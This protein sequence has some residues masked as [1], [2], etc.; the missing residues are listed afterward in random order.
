MAVPDTDTIDKLQDKYAA[1]IIASGH[2][3]PAILAK[4]ELM[5]KLQAK[6][7]RNQKRNPKSEP[8]R[9]GAQIRLRSTT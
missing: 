1:A 4:L 8:P 2:L 9:D 7:A 6:A 3:P 5:G